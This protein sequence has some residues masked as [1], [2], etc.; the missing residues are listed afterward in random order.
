MCV[1]LSHSNRVNSPFISYSQISA[2]A[3]DST[4]ATLTPVSGYLSFQ[5]G[6]REFGITITTVDDSTPEP[7]TFF[8][9]QLTG[10]NGGSRVEPTASSAAV[11][12]KHLYHLYSQSNNLELKLY[13]QSHTF[14]LLYTVLKSDAANGVFG[15]EASSLANSIDETAQVSLA[16]QRLRGDYGRVTLHWEIRDTAT[17]AI[18]SNDFEDATGTLEFSEGNR[19]ETLVVRPLDETDPELDEIFAIYLT[20]AVSN[21]G[22]ASSTPTSGASIDSSLRRSNLTVTENDYPYG[23]LQFST[24]LPPA[25]GLIPAATMTPE[26]AVRESA[27][28]VTVYIV[29]AQG[30]LGTISAEYLTTDGTASGT[31]VNPDY[32]STAGSVEFGP[33][34]RYVSVEITLTDDATP[35]LEKEFYLSLTNP[36][37][38]IIIHRLYGECFISMCL[39]PHSLPHYRSRCARALHWQ[40]HHDQNSPE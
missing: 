9:L 8:T 4:A 17:D 37:G 23:L 25:T 3:T 18:A 33:N 16:V 21:D 31:G 35:E 20:D 14:S 28:T 19:Q 22:F 5:D 26:L 1:S 15:F 12:G 7:S 40:K 6:D 32:V 13:N 34:D 38:G 36:A 11:T 39:P 30:T 29:R 2:I 10:S 24:S 27:G